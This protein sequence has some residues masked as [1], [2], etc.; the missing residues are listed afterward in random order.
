M[1]KKLQIICLLLLLITCR[2]LD[3]N[4]ANDIYS[5]AKLYINDLCF[6]A[7]VTAQQI[8]I[9]FNS[10][11]SKREAVSV[12]RSLGITKVYLEVYRSGMI[13][14]PEVLLSVKTYLQNNGFLVTGG[15]ATVPGKNF[16]IRQ[17]G[18]LGWFN[19]QAEKTIKDLEQVMIQFAPLFD[20]FIVDDFLCTA[21]TSNLSKTA[22]GNQSWEEYRRDL[23]VRLS[24][25]IFINAPKKAHPG[26]KMIIKYP[27]WYDRFHLF[28]YDVVRQPKLFDKVWVGTETRGP[29]TQRMGFVKQYQAFVNFHW[30]SELAGQKIGG[31]WF[32]HIDCDANDFINQAYQ[33]VLAGAKEIVLF[34]YENLIQGH[35]GHHLLRRN[36]SRLL[37][38]AKSVK[39]NLPW[40]V[41]GYKPPQSDAGGDLYIFD[42]LGMLGIPLIPTSIF[43]ENARVVFLPTQAASDKHIEQKINKILENGGVVIFTTGFLKTFGKT[44]IIKKWTGLFPV[45]DQSYITSFRLFSGGTLFEF[46]EG[47]DLETILTVDSAQTLL[48]AFFQ[49]QSVPYLT[50]NNLPSKGKVFVFNFH[51]F[52]EEDFR[53]V[54]EVLLPPRDLSLLKLPQDWISQIRECFNS[55]LEI[56]VKT[57]AKVAVHLLGKGNIVVANYNNSEVEFA[58]KLTHNPETQFYDVFGDGEVLWNEGSTRLTLPGRQIRWLQCRENS[59]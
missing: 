51:T 28:G 14:D 10:E 58:I 53:R 17:E 40:G 27:Q 5:H 34:N 31:A 3:S 12:F 36:F 19:W 21:D 52:S 44:D 39:K 57:P 35:P 7:Y 54:N 46:K 16:G 11:D 20:E 50:R 25:Q 49:N 26:I 23:M 18:Q 4:H 55:A 32:D 42:Y 37:N 43:P 59:P 22:K 8:Q 48:T 41:Y 2:C 9:H 47:L 30:L 45:Y 56:E 29:D 38:L 24:K 13:V 15:I 33:T 6:S 1:S